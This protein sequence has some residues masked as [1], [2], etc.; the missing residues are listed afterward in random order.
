MFADDTQI[1]NKDEDS[2][3]KKSFNVLSTYEKASVSK[4][5]LDKTIGLYIGTWYA[6]WI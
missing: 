5:N 3:K 1:I 6:S 4:I 2:P